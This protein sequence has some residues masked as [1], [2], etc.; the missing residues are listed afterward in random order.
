MRFHQ[1]FKAALLFCIVSTVV[2]QAQGQ[3][4]VTTG[5]KLL[6]GQ[7]PQEFADRRAAVRTAAKGAVVIYR[8]EPEAGEI[9]RVRYRTDNEIMYLTGVEAPGAYLAILPES[10]PS[11]KKEILF[12]P[13]QPVFMKQWVDAILGPGADTEKLTGIESV[14]DISTFWQTIK[15]SISASKLVSVDGGTTEGTKFTS[16]GE[17]VSKL[18]TLV[19]EAT[20][21]GNAARFANVLRYKKS[22]GEIANLRGAIDAT[23]KAELNAAMSIKPG[24]TEIAVEG[25]IIDAFRKGGAPREG[26]PSIVGSGPNSTILHHFA[27]DRAIESGETVVVDI[28]AEYNYYS[29]DITRTFPSSG[30]FTPRQ[31]ELYQLVL[32]CQTAAQKMVVPGKTTLGEQHRFAVDFLKKSPLRAKDA[33]NNLQTMDRFF[34]HG[35]GH[36]LGMDVHD[37]M[38]TSSV[39]I[40]G[41]VFTIEPGLYVPSEN[42][43]IRIEDD[44]HVTETGVEKL[45][46]KIPCTIEDVEAAMKGKVAKR[47]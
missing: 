11:G 12:L 1:V 5:K 4:A 35:L 29:A 46:A 31:R 26:F 25:T 20:I 47:K 34:V 27:S 43:G 21:S 10:D 22:S 37:V 40:P 28:G 7:T 33:G 15:T 8:G 23:G 6:F 17:L 41:V 24:V 45:S 44:Y 2:V 36:S 9:E 16:A 30:K 19:P 18:K 14:V 38:T 32:D 13:N 39:L 3:S 42:I